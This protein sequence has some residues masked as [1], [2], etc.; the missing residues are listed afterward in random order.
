MKN[1]CFIQINSLT[2]THPFPNGYFYCSHFH[3]PFSSN[4]V[5][6]RLIWSTSSNLNSQMSLLFKKL[7]KNDMMVG[8]VSFTFTILCFDGRFW[9]KKKVYWL[10]IQ[11]NW[12]LALTGQDRCLDN[13]RSFLRQSAKTM[14]GECFYQVILR[15]HSSLILSKKGTSRERNLISFNI[16]NK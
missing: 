8:I 2:Y 1:V 11:T 9:L 4:V 7:R 3:W 14:G 10:L 13:Y 5:T 15:A 12:E 16:S 6:L